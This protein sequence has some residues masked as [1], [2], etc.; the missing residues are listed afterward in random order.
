[1]CRNDNHN[2]CFFWGGANHAAELFKFA[3]DLPNA[4]VLF[5]TPGMADVK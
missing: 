3:T 1:M 2:I 4:V 5:A